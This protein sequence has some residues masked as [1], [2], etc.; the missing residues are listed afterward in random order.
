MLMSLVRR[1]WKRSP[2]RVRWQAR[3]AAR[4]ER[5]RSRGVRIGERCVILT[6]EFSLEPYLVE[7]G[8]GVAVSGGTVFLTH[9]GAAW[10]L[11]R[12]R[13]DA[14]HFGRIRVGDDTFIGQNCVILPGTRIGTNCVVGAGSVVRGTIPDNSVVLGN[15]AT[16][17]GRTGLF[18]EMMN[19]SRDTLDTYSQPEPERERRIREHFRLS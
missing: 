15:P 5:L 1:L 9:D 19:A 4:I 12:T 8:D 17:I 10:L 13:P 18:L 7:I 3:N 11:R 6:D 16:V 2:A 14:Q